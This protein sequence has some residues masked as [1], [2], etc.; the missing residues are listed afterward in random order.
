MWEER[1][2]KSSPSDNPVRRSA[3]APGLFLAEIDCGAKLNA[4]DGKT[5][6]LI[7]T[8]SNLLRRIGE[9]RKTIRETQNVRDDFQNT[10]VNRDKAWQCLQ[11]LQNKMNSL[12]EPARSQARAEFELQ[13]AEHQ[14]LSAKA[15]RLWPQSNETLAFIDPFSKD[16]SLLLDRIPLKPEWDVYRDA[17]G[18]LD[19]N[20]FGSWTDPPENSAL[21][22]LEVRLTEMLDLAGT[23]P[24]RVPRNHASRRNRGPNLEISRQRVEMEDDLRTEL[25]TVV[26]ELRQTRSLSELRKKFPKFQIWHMLSG[27]EQELLLTEPV[28]PAGYAKVLVLRHFGLTSEETLKKDRKKLRTAANRRQ[29]G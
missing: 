27:P 8:I 7:E 11:D 14:K 22:T 2:T 28:K 6:D 21:E 25:A 1:H 18:K 5:F 16:V 10:Y 13:V 24:G 19:V 23:Q 26:V 12:E 29:L 3:A 15:E 9:G 20:P 17:V 4:M